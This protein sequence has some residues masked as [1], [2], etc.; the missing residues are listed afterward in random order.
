[1]LICWVMEN[2]KQWRRN[3]ALVIHVTIPFYPKLGNGKL[4]KEIYWTVVLPTKLTKSPIKQSMVIVTTYDQVQHDERFWYLGYCERR[5]Q[6]LYTCVMLCLVVK[7]VSPHW[8]SFCFVNYRWVSLAGQGK[9]CLRM[10]LLGIESSIWP[11]AYLLHSYAHSV[12]LWKLCH[13]SVLHCRGHCYNDD[14]SH[15]LGV[16]VLSIEVLSVSV[17]LPRSP[18]SWWHQQSTQMWCHFLVTPSFMLDEPIDGVTGQPATQHY[19]RTVLW[20][21]N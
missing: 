12:W 14:I 8:Y 21:I 17:P 16:T 11:S 3:G 18:L 20:L 10:V 5:D 13:K 2:W 4:A 9:C 19:Q 6:K 15:N 7:K 1:L